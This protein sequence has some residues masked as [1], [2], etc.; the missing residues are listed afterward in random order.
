MLPSRV[1]RG[2]NDC[3]LMLL[4]ALDTSH[5]Q[6]D[7][8]MAVRSQRGRGRFLLQKK[9]ETKAKVGRSHLRILAT[10]VQAG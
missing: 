5:S 6:L 3:V 1:I 9:K 4:P 2:Q 8:T 7:V 10:S